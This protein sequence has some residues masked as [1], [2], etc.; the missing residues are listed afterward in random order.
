MNQIRLQS[1]NHSLVTFILFWA[2]LTIL[3]C[4]YTTIPLTSTWMN[5]FHIN[6]TQAVW[7]TSSFSLCYALTSFIYGPLSDKFGRKIFLVI[8]ISL[9]TIFTIICSFIDNY[10]FFII[11]RILQASGASA[12]VPIS[13]VYI[14]EIFP[15][16]KRLKT[17]GIVASSF[18][19]ASVAA[20]VFSSIIH[21]LFN[22]QT[23]FII[24]GIL[25][26]ITFLL[27][28]F[29][30]PKEQFIKQKNSTFSNYMNMK[31]LFKK[32]SLCISFLISFMML[33]S[34][35]GMYT[36]L[37]TFLSSPPFNFTE[38]QILLI[39]GIGLLAVITSF[40]ANSITMRFGIIKSVRGSLLIAGFSLFM[41]GIT[42]NAVMAISFSVFFVACIALLVP[43]NITLIQ[44][45]AEGQRATAVLLNAFIL[46][47][48]ASVGPMLATQLLHV[49]NTLIAFTVFSLI[50]FFGFVSTLLLKN[51]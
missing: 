14:T 51:K 6:E 29:Y 1:F 4:M 25:Y 18:L 37:G 47:I 33:F 8:G 21:S 26:F 31:L 23:I 24:L 38:H 28:I 9:L 15:Q 32:R 39:R 49:T 17:T 3:M 42:S 45:Q 30:L 40:F 36:M 43:V 16:E 22:W 20:Q 19:L 12:F 44:Q 50:L 2:G 34:L 13:L 7:L 27:T 48:G 10:V 11:L 46:F 35:I 5:E 41:M